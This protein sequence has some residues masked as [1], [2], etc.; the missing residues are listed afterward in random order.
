MTFFEPCTSP[1][2]FLVFNRLD[3]TA[4]VFEVIKK[5]KPP[6]LYVAA[7]GHRKN[8][9][10]EQEK[11]AAVRNYVL[12]NIDWACDV[13]T[14]FR[15]ENMG[16]KNAVSSAISWFFDNEGHGI[17]LEDD[18]LPSLSFF[19]F[20]D[21]LLAK[22]AD[23]SMVMSISG[24]N[25]L[26]DTSGHYSESYHFSKYFH[27]WGWASWRRAWQGYDK[28]MAA[29]EKYSAENK[30]QLVQPD[31][32]FSAYWTDIFNE[33]YEG[34]IDTWDYQM[35]FHVLQSEGVCCTP[36]K[37]LVTNIG[38]GKDATHTSDK[39]L[40]AVPAFQLNFPLIHPANAIQNT[41]LDLLESKIEFKITVKNVWKR[42]FF[43]SRL[44]TAIIKKLGLIKRAITKQTK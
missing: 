17:V 16:C 29:W 12:E 10:G 32:A 42:R 6:K 28:K 20:C 40:V 15:A 11:C 36:S 21:E 1:V 19:G 41:S 37:N 35:Y 22:Y 44:V 14:L 9:I 26:G 13:K 8:K 34:K 5:A 3:T 27:C 18:C 7:D 23:N 38:F 31:W 39:N 33:V 30:L 25:A 2:L 43:T 24:Y 4:K